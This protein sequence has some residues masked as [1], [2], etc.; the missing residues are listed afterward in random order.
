MVQRGSRQTSGG[1]RRRTRRV[2]YSKARSKNYTAA[3]RGIKNDRAHARVID[4]APL[5]HTLFMC[6]AWRVSLIPGAPVIDVLT[7]IEAGSCNTGET[8]WVVWGGR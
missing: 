6:S 5:T 8:R 7:R 2:G 3:A 4:R 1:G